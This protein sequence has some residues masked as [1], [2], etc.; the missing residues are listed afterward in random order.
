MAQKQTRLREFIIGV[1][2]IVQLITADEF[3]SSDNDPI[4]EEDVTF[5]EE[6]M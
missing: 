3:D 4:D 6:A 1:N 5:L 2:E